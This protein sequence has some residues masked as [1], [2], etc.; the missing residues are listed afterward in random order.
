MHEQH[1]KYQL[2]GWL[3]LCGL[4]S[5]FIYLDLIK[6]LVFLLFMHLVSDLLIHSLGDR[7]N[8]IS[9]RVI[10]YA[11]YALVAA[12]IVTFVLLVVPNLVEDLPVYLNTVENALGEKVTALLADLGI[13][14]EIGDLKVKLIELG[15]RH[16]SESFSL[17]IR[18]GKDILLLLFAFVI[19]FLL[20]HE[21]I[22]NVT[23]YPT[24]IDPETRLEF[25]SAFTI[26]NVSVFYSHFHQV[27]GAQFIISLINTLLTIVLLF[28]LGVPHKVSL[29]VLVFIFGL[30]P[31]VGNLISNTIICISAL[32]WAGPWQLVAS[33]VFLV[34]IHKLEYFLNSKIIGNRVQL[35]M[36][37]ILL[38]LIIGESLFHISGMILA[39]PVI[40]FV[41]AELH[42][43]KY[44]G[45]V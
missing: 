40:L 2:V 41:R 39:V 24:K 36:Y 20:M 17:A 12:L 8:F 43:I 23:D 25:L 16:F 34:I 7:V 21:K 42:A 13:P 18:V 44:E 19:N 10:L 9:K 14:I 22:A 30:L 5:L 38:G 31:I 45:C 32:L 1:T 3:C 27:M 26:D 29:T 28:V 11:A 15:K 35:P 33:L 6:F 37:M 4:L